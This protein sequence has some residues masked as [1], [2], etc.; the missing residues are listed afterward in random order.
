MAFL[1]HV[2]R[3]LGPATHLMCPDAGRLLLTYVDFVR[4]TFGYEPFACGQ[5][6]YWPSS[7]HR[8]AHVADLSEQ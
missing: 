3:L 7:R 2:T 1:N 6:F 5:S 4:T 8:F